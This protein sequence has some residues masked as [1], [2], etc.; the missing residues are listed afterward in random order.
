[1]L[2]SRILTP[3]NLQKSCLYGTLGAFRQARTCVKYP[4]VTSAGDSFIGTPSGAFFMQIALR[5]MDR[6]GIDEEE[7]RSRGDAGQGQIMDTQYEDLLKAE[8]TSEMTVL[9]HQECDLCI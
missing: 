3:V 7:V 8:T 1:M 5:Q 9:R 4:I 2:A 6:Q